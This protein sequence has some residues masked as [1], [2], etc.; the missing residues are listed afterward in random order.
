MSGSGAKSSA[1]N[2]SGVAI[3]FEVVVTSGG[4]GVNLSFLNLHN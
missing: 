4:S 3:V 2:T 1:I